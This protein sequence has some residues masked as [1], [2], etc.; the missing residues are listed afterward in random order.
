MRLST[1]PRQLRTGLWYGLAA[2]GAWG[3]VPLY[4]KSVDCPAHEIVAHRV[5][6]SFVVLAIIIGILG[7]WRDFFGIFLKRNL[8]LMLTASGYLVAANW[9]VYVYSATSGQ[10]MQAS[11]GY[12]LL[13]LV[14]AFVGVAYFRERLS[15]AQGAALSLAGVGVAYMA[16]SVG[17]F[18]WIGIT[19][20]I[21]FSIYGV[22]RKLVIS[23]SLSPLLSGSIRGR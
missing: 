14:N 10:I 2:Y 1:D 7:R 17:V 19:L 3:L 8:V 15:R 12:F 9:Y 4:F 18:P 20:A 22:M 16:L 6:W 21:T 11:L 23:F 5:L 13:P